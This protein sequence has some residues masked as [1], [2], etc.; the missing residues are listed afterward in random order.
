[1]KIAILHLG[2]FYSG[3]GEK[4]V[5]EE[6]RGLRSM[7][8]EVDCYAPYVDRTSCFPD[9]PEIQEIRSL[10]PPP[11]RWLPMHDPLWVLLSSILAPLLGFRFREYDVLIGANQPGPWLAYV[12]GKLLRKPYIIYLAQ[13]LRLLHLRD[14]DLVNGIRIREGDHQFLMTIRKLAGWIIDKAD[15]ISVRNASAVLTN[16]EHVGHWIYEVYG[17]RSINCAAGCHPLTGASL[18]YDTRWSGEISINGARIQKPYIL[19]TNRHSPMKRFEYAI[20]AMKSIHRISGDITLVITGQ[21]TEYTDQL[22]YLVDGLRLNDAVKFVGLVSEDELGRLYRS[23]SAYVYPSPEEDFGMGIVEAM[24]AGTPVVA[25][26]NGG[27]TVTVKDK[28]TGFLVEPYDTDHF[29]DRLLTL[30]SNPTLSEKLGRAANLRARKR[31][32]YDQH[33]RVLEEAALSA[34]HSRE[35]LGGTARE[36]ASN[37]QWLED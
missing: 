13:P 20:W 32:S 27:P 1:M 8:H 17:V 19:L 28:E 31:F 6:L 7:G 25:W 34:V 12:L 36:P 4:L 9:Y 33:N 5:L 14:I 3:G 15:R 22:R 11:P 30:A 21:E 37:A 2:F 24:G 29:A 26:A 18:S 23:A 16:G 35:V 10:L